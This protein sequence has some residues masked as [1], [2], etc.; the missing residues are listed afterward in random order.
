MPTSIRL[1]RET[2]EI[3]ALITARTGS[4]RSE[5]IRTAIR[6]L[7]REEPLPAETAYDTMADL[8]GVAAGGTRQYAARSEEVLRELLTR[9]RR[10]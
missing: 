9:K 3:V 7:A 4:T 8:L 1:D 5:V 6:R 2:E 10:R